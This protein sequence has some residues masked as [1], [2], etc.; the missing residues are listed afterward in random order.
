MITVDKFQQSDRDQ[1]QPM[2]ALSDRRVSTEEQV[3]KKVSLAARETWLLVS[4]K[5]VLDRLRLGTLK[6]VKGE[7]SGKFASEIWR[8]SS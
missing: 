1:L 8:P 3:K 4:E 2:G 7:G 5:A 6:E